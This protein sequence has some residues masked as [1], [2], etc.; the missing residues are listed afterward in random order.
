MKKGKKYLLVRFIT[1]IIVK[2]FYVT[3]ST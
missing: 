3:L 2:T 1:A